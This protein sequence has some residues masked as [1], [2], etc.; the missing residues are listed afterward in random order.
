MGRSPE[1]FATNPPVFEPS[2]ISNGDRVDLNDGLPFYAIDGPD[3]HEIDDAIQIIRRKG[4][5]LVQVAIA[6]GL[7]LAEYNNSSFVEKAISKKHNKYYGDKVTKQILPTGISDALSLKTG[8]NDTLVIRQWFD[9][10]GYT[11]RPTEIFPA[12]AGIIRTTYEEF[13]RQSSK[14]G[15]L[16]A[17]FDFY[18]NFRDWNGL[19]K[20]SLGQIVAQKGPAS[21]GISLVS[22]TMV[23]TNIAVANWADEQQLPIIYRQFS[24][25]EYADD[26]ISPE[27]NYAHYVANPFPHMGITGHKDGVKYT[28]VTSP[29]R[30]TADLLN[31]LQIGHLLAKEVL[32]YS[33]PELATI[34]A[35]LNPASKLATTALKLE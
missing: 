35:K 6:D 11:S 15:P 32:P 2:K 29:L 27:I 17:Y 18:E 26:D 25:N 9:N 12:T 8:E 13:G 3:A 31:H 7:K 23:L 10:Y 24:T 21:L 30:R 20:K 16:G 1:A 19:R 22:S 28:H 33:Q 4:G 5:F 14:T 34:S